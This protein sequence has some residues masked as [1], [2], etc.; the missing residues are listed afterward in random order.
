MHL[1]KVWNAFRDP[2]F[3]KGNP[4]LEGDLKRVSMSRA[5]A[6]VVLSTCD[7]ADQV[8]GPDQSTPE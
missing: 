3:R 1:E 4:H 7:S 5:R 2:R 8:L 6:I